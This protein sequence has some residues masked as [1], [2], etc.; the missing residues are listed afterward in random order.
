M[1]NTLAQ[2]LQYMFEQVSAKEVAEARVR[3]LETEVKN[4]REQ[5]PKDKVDGLATSS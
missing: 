2:I 4:L 1:E 5:M 3:E